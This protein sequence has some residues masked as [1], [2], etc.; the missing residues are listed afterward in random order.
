MGKIFY[1]MGKSASGKD[2][3]YKKLLEA[4]PQLHTVTLYVTRPMRV[5]E[6]DGVEYHFT[7]EKEL[8]AFQDAGKVIEQR[9]YQTVAGPWSYATVDDDVRLERALLREKQ[10][11]FP[12]YAELCRRYLADEKDFSPENLKE[13]GILQEYCNHNLE[14]CVDLIKKQLLYTVSNL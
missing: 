9:T 7:T 2:T 14:S 5:G 13:A 3:I 10:Q 6:R 1:L 8:K 12:N 4:C 11:K